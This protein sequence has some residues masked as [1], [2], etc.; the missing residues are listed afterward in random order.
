MKVR[1]ILQR[2]LVL[3][4]LLGS[5]AFAGD[6]TCYGNTSSTSYFFCGAH[7][8]CTWWAAYKRPDLAAKIS[9]GGWDGGLWHDKFK[10]LGFSVGSEPRTFA[11]VGFAG[12]GNNPAGHVSYVEKSNS[13]GSFDASEMDWFGSLGTGNGVQ[14]ATYHPNGDGTYRRNNG[15]TR[16]VLKGFIYK[17]SCDFTKERCNIR[18]SGSIGWFPSVSDCSQASQWFV[19]GTMNGE[20]M[21]IGTASAADCPLMCVAPN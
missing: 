5:M 7:G 3:C 9:G 12:T 14:N 4:M 16:W 21:P 19:I 6:L 10:N 11:I 2:V 20:R 1:M 15:S 17:K 8:N 13:D 18:I